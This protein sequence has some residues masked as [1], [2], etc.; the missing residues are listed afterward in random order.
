[1]IKGAEIRSKRLSNAPAIL[2]WV[3]LVTLLGLPW[4]VIDTHAT[5]S[6]FLDLKNDKIQGESAT[7]GH[8][9]E[10][11]VLSM[12]F[13]AIASASGF[14]PGKSTFQD[15]SIAKYTDKT[16]PE[17]MRRLLTGDPIS[18]AKIKF[19][20]TIN[21]KEVPVVNFELKDNRVTSLSTG[22]AAGQN[23]LTEILILN[24]EQFS[25]ETF[26]H[27]DSGPEA[28]DS[29]MT[30]DSKTGTGNLGGINNSPPTISA[31]EAQTINEDGSSLAV[32][33]TIGDPETPAGSLTVSR[34]TSNPQVVPLSGIALGGAG[35]NRNAVITPAPNANGSATVSI[36]VADTYGL[37]TTRSF[38][39][40]V[41]A[42][43]DAPTI[44]E[45]ANQVTNQ[46]RAITTGINVV[47]I[48]TAPASVT[49]SAV[50]GNPSLIPAANITFSGSGAATLMTLR[51]VPGASGSALITLRAND[52]SAN[53]Y[54]VSFTLTV[55][56]GDP[57]G[58]TDIAWQVPPLI[59][60]DSTRDTVVGSLVT[61]DPNHS[62][63]QITYSL[64]DSAGG[65]FKAGPLGSILVANGKL[66]DFET[67][68]SHAITVRAT[69]P[70]ANAFEKV[71]QIELSNVNER[72][73]I[74][75]T[76]LASVG[77]F[78][79]LP[80]A[81]L[82]IEDPDAGSALIAVTF[83][84]TGGY[85]YLDESGVLGGKV[86]GNESGSVTVTA[87]T[88]DINSV[89]AAGGLTYY[90]V[91][92]GTGTIPLRIIANDQGNA[93]SGGP[94]S[95]STT[96]D[97]TVIA[98][99]VSKLA[100]GLR[101]GAS[102]D[103]QGAATALNSAVAPSR[104]NQWQQAHFPTQVGDPSISGSLADSDKDGIANLLEYG[105]GTD[106]NDPADG[107]GAVV[108][109]EEIVD[110]IAYPAI[111]FKRLAAELDPSLIVKVELATDQFNWRTEP[112]DTAEVRSTP[113][114][115]THEDVVIRSTLP[116]S[117]E[118]R[119]LMRLRFSLVP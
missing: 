57:T 11:D 94:K 76:P 80:I 100:N 83:G 9:G 101:K 3:G 116:I 63:N 33:F 53:S 73:V 42:I 60:E 5:V 96:L 38:T 8:K 15:I 25:I 64:L 66:L 31:I 118:V 48:D 65:R 16:T 6:I 30:W 105:V 89:L 52:G 19:V 10:I 108:F 87:S 44:Q 56:P 12:S 36:T 27:E 102:G 1:V 41:K 82:S 112:G 59:A 39:I 22:G 111:R 92:V 37:T 61:S 77:Q 45:I 71:L 51:P 79:S 99:Q 114:S 117:G 93:G 50:S 113:F 91:E 13:G 84:V 110:G 69:D 40:T 67:S 98:G 35:T 29:I 81:G 115:A 32:P 58:P 49:V 119:Q 106:P 97:I 55:R 23:E 17:L 95:T 43:N 62:N 14:N 103:P 28:R 54:G 7:K 26:S 74:A 24:F 109:T 104:F 86:S 85:L 90:A 47:D 4:F 34:S 20:E 78:G 70:D 75:S 72:P 46:N 21:G 18:S 2:R 88:A 107:P 68:P